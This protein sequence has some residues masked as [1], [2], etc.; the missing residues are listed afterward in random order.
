MKRRVM[1]LLGPEER[2]SARHKGR[3]RISG[4][5]DCHVLDLDQKVAEESDGGGVVD[6]TSG[7]AGDTRSNY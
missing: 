6:V 3:R 2:L 4:R 7:R 5:A 1:T